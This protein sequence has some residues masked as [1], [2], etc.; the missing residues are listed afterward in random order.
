MLKDL[1]GTL[2]EAVFTNKKSYISAQA[3][4]GKV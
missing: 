4:P 2:I 3:F 1:L